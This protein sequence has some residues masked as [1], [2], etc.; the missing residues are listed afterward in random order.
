MPIRAAPGIPWTRSAEIETVLARGASGVAADTFDQPNAAAMI[1]EPARFSNSSFADQRERFLVRARTNEM[2][3]VRDREALAE[4]EDQST[5]LERIQAIAHRLA[6]VGPASAA[7]TKSEPK[8]LLWKR[9]R[10]P[11]ACRWG[12]DRRP[13]PP[14]MRS[15]MSSIALRRPQKRKSSAM[16]PFPRSRQGGVPGVARPGVRRDRLRRCM[17]TRATMSDDKPSTALIAARRK[18]LI[19]SGAPTSPMR[20]RMRGWLAGAA[21]IASLAIAAPS[22]GA[23]RLDGFDVI[24]SRGHPFGSA[25]ARKSLQ[26]ARGVGATAIA[27]IPFLW[28]P[29][30]AKPAI[31]RGSDMT[32]EEFGQ[33]ILDAAHM[34]SQP[35][36]SR[37]SGSR[38]A[39]PAR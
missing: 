10:L 39:G 5:A 26:L 25:S 29:S 32:D 8:L 17:P 35:S 4:G 31:V 14:S 7:W 3:L 28:Q 23:A 1:G 15:S 16:V 34:V 11:G 18:T 13:R 36:S 20:D 21:I 24:A 38:G 30:S 37:R 2:A 12:S 27:I 33:A 19:L 9:R 6:E 22:L